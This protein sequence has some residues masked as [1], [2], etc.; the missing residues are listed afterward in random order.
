MQKQTQ[1]R[2][3]YFGAKL[4][5]TQLESTSNDP[6]HVF[7]HYKTIW[8]GTNDALATGKTVKILLCSNRSMIEEDD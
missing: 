5:N 8:Q 3:V 7:L 6:C 4:N 2:G 1:V